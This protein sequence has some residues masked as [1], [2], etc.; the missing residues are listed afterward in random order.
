MQPRLS[1]ESHRSLLLIYSNCCLSFFDCFVVACEW[2]MRKLVWCDHDGLKMLAEAFEE[3]A[4]CFLSVC[5][6]LNHWELGVCPVQSVRWH[7]LLLY[8]FD[9]SCLQK[10][11]E[12]LPCKSA[13]SVICEKKKNLMNV[14]NKTDAGVES[15]LSLVWTALQIGNTE[16]RR[17][18]SLPEISYLLL[19]EDIRF[20]VKWS[21]PPLKY[22]F[23]FLFLL[24]NCSLRAQCWKCTFSLC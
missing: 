3:V 23:F 13:I 10:L 6:N 21:R 19:Q 20:S 18:F 12:I 7:W 17:Q 16:P 9:F 24:S 4:A 14:W 8:L 1:P 11:L 15:H 5:G 2:L 22:L